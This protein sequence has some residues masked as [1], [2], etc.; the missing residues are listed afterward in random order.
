M[1]TRSKPKATVLGVLGGSG[2]YEIEGLQDVRA[3]EVT[4][5]YGPPS[6]PLVSGTV[7]GGQLVFIPRHGPGH[8]LS[9]SEINYRANVAA[10]KAAGATRVLSVSA[11]GSLKE[12]LSP[13]DYLLVDQFIDKT[14]RRESTFFGDG[15]VGHVAFAEP[16][17]ASLMTAVATA[18]LEVGIAETEPEA[19]THKKELE[20]VKRL[21]RGGTYVCMEGPQFSSRAE[22]LLHRS[23]GADVIG[24]TAATE[25]KLCREA[26]LCYASLALVTDYD[27]WHDE[28]AAVTAAAVVAVLQANVAGAKAIICEL[29]HHASGPTN[30]SCANAAR[31]AI[32]TAPEAITPEA[33]QRLRALYGRDI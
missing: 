28:E 3:V 24:M 10:L 2:L 30:C 33:R 23:W 31:H 6:G 13:G 4:T 15:V 8:R 1:T 9:P 12:G 26:E 18:A 29:P 20:P 5:P 11:V 16:T 27:A 17:C 7:S 21:H 32:L 22:S 14:F 19:R 25:A